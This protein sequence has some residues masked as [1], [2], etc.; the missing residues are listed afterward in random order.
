[1]SVDPYAPPAAQAAPGD[2]ARWVGRAF[3]ASREGDDLAI[4]R[5]AGL[6]DACVGCGATTIAAR[7]ARPFMAMPAW[8]RAIAF[9]PVVAA[10]V[11][12][13]RVGDGEVS[14]VANVVIV[15]SLLIV[16]TQRKRAKLVLPTCAP[17][18]AKYVKRMRVV[19][20]ATLVLILG[21]V[22]PIWLGDAPDRALLYVAAFGAFTI[23]TLLARRGA[24]RAIRIDDRSVV[25]R[26]VHPHAAQAI[27][28][29]SRGA[30]LDQPRA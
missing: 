22:A 26:G 18:D 17:C 23:V 11:L 20:L 4:E 3:A 8:A 1:M 6:P 2:G 10:A 5:D 12:L 15:V 13:A 24:I 25:L 14:L 9:V 19:A 28:D 30:V 29:A 16:F 27:L 21:C 7:R